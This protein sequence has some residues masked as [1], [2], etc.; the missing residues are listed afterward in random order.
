MEMREMPIHAKTIGK[1]ER[2]KKENAQN[3]KQ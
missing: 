1:N 3:P 2:S